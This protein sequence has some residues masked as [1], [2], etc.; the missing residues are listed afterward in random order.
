MAAEQ[1]TAAD[2][3]CIRLKRREQAKKEVTRSLW[4]PLST[5]STP[6]NLREAIED[7][8]DNTTAE[9]AAF[10]SL[11]DDLAFELYGLEVRP[12]SRP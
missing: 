8:P 12:K 11:I 10:Q 5:G 6:L 4:P 2:R 1:L 9:L 7:L 3:R